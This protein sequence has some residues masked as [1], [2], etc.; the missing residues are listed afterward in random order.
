MRLSVFSLLSPP[1]PLSPSHL[2]P[3]QLAALRRLTT[4]YQPNSWFS[5]DTL[6]QWLAL[7]SVPD[8]A[9]LCKSLCGLTVRRP[10]E[11]TAMSLGDQERTSTVAAA[12]ALA[13]ST[14]ASGDW[15]VHLAKSTPVC[16]ADPI[17][18]RAWYQREW[19]RRLWR[20]RVQQTDEENERQQRCREEE[21]DETKTEPHDHENPAQASWDDL[22]TAAAAAAT[23]S[24]GS[25]AATGPIA[26]SLWH[27]FP[28]TRFGARTFT[29]W[30]VADDGSP[31]EGAPGVRE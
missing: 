23:A 27:F 11:W 5:L 1:S 6:H 10:A 8:A 2:L 28:H 3:L 14:A 24:D 15:A 25:S 9:V 16:E 30:I 19:K 12:N 29:E 21:E 20:M 17:V 18:F 7:P 13:R 4:V 31:D 22:P 26:S